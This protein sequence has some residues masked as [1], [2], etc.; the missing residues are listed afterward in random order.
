MKSGF[1]YIINLSVRRPLVK[2]P[3]ATGIKKER[4]AL[5][6]PPRYY[7][8]L[9]QTLLSADSVSAQDCRFIH[10][11][12]RA[13]TPSAWFFAA[14]SVFPR[15]GENQYILIVPNTAAP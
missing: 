15:A 12:K 11:Q 4:S 1:P 3:P 8:A 2:R 6:E 13:G 7:S 5:M 14:L 9:I 10:A